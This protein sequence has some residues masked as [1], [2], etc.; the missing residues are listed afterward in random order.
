MDFA[1]LVKRR[2]PSQL[3]MFSPCGHFRVG[4]NDVTDINT[5]WLPK[6]LQNRDLQSRS[7]K[8]NFFEIAGTSE[9]ETS[10]GGKAEC[11]LAIGQRLKK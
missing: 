2:M 4:R 8:T 7:F 3:Q 10:V 9:A 5:A 11:L 1:D 6:Q